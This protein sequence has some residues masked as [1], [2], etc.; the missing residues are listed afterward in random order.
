M[1][2]GPG[3]MIAIADPRP[4]VDDLFGE[5][6]RAKYPSP[7][8]YKAWRIL[9]HDDR[10]SSENIDQVVETIMRRAKQKGKKG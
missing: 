3:I 7:E 10:A 6:C 4:P 2:E 8:F 9:R 1:E 5:L